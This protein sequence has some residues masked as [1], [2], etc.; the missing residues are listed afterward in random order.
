M[1]SRYLIPLA[2]AAALAAPVAAH[3][4]EGTYDPGKWLVRVG[5]SQINPDSYNLA[6]APHCRRRRQRPVADGDGRVHDHAAHRHRTAGGVAV[7]ARPRPRHRQP[8]ARPRRAGRRAAAD[9]EPQLALQSERLGPPLH[10]CGRQLHAVLGR[11]NPRRARRHQPRSSTTA[12]APP[13]RSVSTSASATGSSMPTSATS[14]CRP[15]SSL[16]GADLGTRRPEPVGVRSARRLSL[17]P[18]DPAGPGCRTG[19]RA[20]APAARR[21]PSARTRMATASATKPTSARA[22]RPARRSTRSAARSSRP[23]SSCSTSTAPSCAPS[24]SRNSSAS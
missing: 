4:Q 1:S 22:P 3:A 21:P 18:H 5:M 9:A 15:T 2:V 23:S 11:R 16:D 17:R 8:S 20:A 14:T 7:Y 6:W 12:S 13:A 19:R 24:R 10:R